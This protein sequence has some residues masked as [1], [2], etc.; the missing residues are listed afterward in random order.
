LIDKDT[1]L[2]DLRVSSLVLDPPKDVDQLVDL[3][4]RTLRYILDVHAPLGTKE[5]PRRPVLP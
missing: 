2:A 4:D 3:Y 5:M 1:F